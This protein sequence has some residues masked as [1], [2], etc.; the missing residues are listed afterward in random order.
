VAKFSSSFSLGADLLKHYYPAFALELRRRS[1]DAYDFAKKYPGVSQTAPC[2]APYFYEEDN[3]VDDMELA[4]AQLFIRSGDKKYL[5]DAVTFGAMEPVTPWLGADTARHYQWYPFVNL[6]HFL[7]ARDSKEHSRQFITHMREGIE[8]IYQ[9]GKTNAFNFGVPFIW[10]S[11][12]LVSSLLT[13]MYLYRTLTKDESYIEMESSL[14][15]WLF[16]CNPWGTSMVVGLPAYGDTPSDPHSAFTHVYNFPISGGLVDGPVRATIFDQHK[17]YIR[18][19]KAD[20]YAEF[21]SA[22]AVYHDDWGDYTNNE[23][24]MDGTAGLTMYLSSLEKK[25]QKSEQ[26]SV[27]RFG[28]IIRFDTT[29]KNIYLLFTGHEFA[30]GGPTILRTLRKH[31]IKGSFFFTGDFYRNKNFTPIIKQLKKE[32]HYLGAHSG[33]HLL[34]APWVKRDSLLVDK[35]TFVDDLKDNYKEMN[36]FGIRST[37]AKYF[38][39]P[40]EWYNQTISDWTN[41]YGLEL[42]NFSSGTSSNADYTTPDMANYIPS[43]SIVTRILRYESASTTGLNGFLLLSHIGTSELRTKKFYNRLDEVIVELKRRGYSFKKLQ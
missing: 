8:K 41:Y 1:V 32:D 34:Y 18:L 2:R 19:T 14:R 16:G 10:C 38:L 11:N 39:P 35:N 26:P 21:Q 43:D 22:L 31:N 36:K 12:N 30:D 15:D 42:V 7:I 9:K 28:G 4:A 25:E 5:N 3:W 27:V 29:K 23:P 6:G 20:P 40:Y 24:T 17:K 37:D 33:K 13:Q